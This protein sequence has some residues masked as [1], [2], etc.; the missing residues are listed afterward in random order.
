M[1]KLQKNKIGKECL[2]NGRSVYTTP[3]RLRPISKVIRDK[4]F[5]VYHCYVSEHMTTVQTA[6]KFNMCVARIREI[7]KWAVQE[8]GE[9]DP[10]AQLQQMLDKISIRQQKIDAEFKKDELVMSKEDKLTIDEKL[11]L[12]REQRANDLLESK[13]SGLITTSP[14]IDNSDNRTL[15]VKKAEGFSRREAIDTGDANG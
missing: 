5:E 15:I 11:A 3:S 12:F 13:I 7:I 1:K 14:V 8:I 9:I 10:N 6:K 2:S 4:Y